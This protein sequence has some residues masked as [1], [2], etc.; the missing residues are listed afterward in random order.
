MTK[1]FFRISAVILIAFAGFITIIG[2][3]G[4]SEDSLNPDDP[5][6]P[7]STNTRPVASPLSLQVEPSSPN[8]EIN[9]IGSDVDGDTLQY[10][11]VSPNSGPGYLSASVESFTGKLLVTLDV[12]VGETIIIAI[13]RY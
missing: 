6:D 13:S 2:S 5:I 1:I 7:N 9:L 3:G 11:L 10:E 8:L 4:G 12:N